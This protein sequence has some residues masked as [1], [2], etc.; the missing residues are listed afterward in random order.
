[1][2]KPGFVT[3]GQP[4]IYCQAPDGKVLHRQDDYGGPEQLA[5]A[6]RKAKPNY[7]PEND[8][9][10]NRPLDAAKQVPG[11]V[12]VIAAVL[13]LLVATRTKAPNAKV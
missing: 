13:A 1:M 8:P 6:A 7:R 9:N 5:E 3:S 12:W 2:A 4:T 10:V 11:I